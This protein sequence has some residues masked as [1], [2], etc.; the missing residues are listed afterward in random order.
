MGKSQIFITLF[1]GFLLVFLTSCKTEFEK[2]R[3]SNDPKL[4]LE[5]GLALYDEEKYEQ[6]Q[7]L[8]EQAISAYRGQK[9]A[10]ELFFKYAYTHYHLNQFILAAHYFK[11]FA[12]TFIN[13]DKRQ[14]ADFMAAYSNVR[15]SPSYRLDQTYT[16]QAI[17]GLQT[18]VNTY[19]ES[20]RVEECNELID[21]L[22]AKLE[23]KL[24]EEGKLYYDLREYQ[25]ADQSFSNLLKEYPGTENGEEV[26]Y[27][28]V[29]SAYNLAKNSV[30]EKR[31]P[32]FEETIKRANQF[33]KKYPGNKKT[34]EIQ[35]IRNLSKS[36]IK[37]LNNE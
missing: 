28:L 19:P 4:M 2:I 6:A 32:R 26:R 9:E 14:E 7:I 12:N 22:R 20:E 24:F 5:K 21:Q 8:L 1:T 27:L 34:R 25:S 13:S 36:S 15:N 23:K 29:L 37:E 11:N 31:K 10:E 33:I 3:Q 16:R 18:F 17:D 35:E 30:Y